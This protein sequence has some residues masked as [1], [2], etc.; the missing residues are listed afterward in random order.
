[1]QSNAFSNRVVWIIM[2]IVVNL[3]SSA[4]E[5][6]EGLAMD[7]VDKRFLEAVRNDDDAAYQHARDEALRLP[8][9]DFAALLQSL[10]KA[11]TWQSM[12]IHDALRLRREQPDLAADFDDRLQETIN[13]PTLARDGTPVYSLYKRSTVR[14][15]LLTPEHD[16][17]RFEASLTPKTQLHDGA[18]DYLR[19]SLI[20]LS[21]RDEHSL[22]RYI[23]LIA[24]MPEWA[25]TGGY[26]PS[27]HVEI[28]AARSPTLIDPE[29]SRLVDVYKSL[30]RDGAPL[31]VAI[32]L[33]RAIAHGSPK[34]STP[35]LTAIRRHELELMPKQGVEPWAVRNVDELRNK[36]RE[37]TKVIRSLQR[38]QQA[39]LGRADDEEAIEAL[40]RNLSAAEEQLQRDRTVL[41]A[42]RLW[43][44]LEDAIA[45][46][47]AAPDGNGNGRN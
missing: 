28:I 42:V 47:E 15:L 5:P 24:D 45:K 37:T 19:S 34:V 9:D 10:D 21:Q 2:S 3:V 17:L 26:H 36:T 6:G 46:T 22:R 43:R 20:H 11:G 18:R 8:P 12:A 30:R 23:A 27:N 7:S 41:A 13:N 31:G 35:A 14:G 33:V 16:T 25:S 38:K 1:M 44:T 32:M 39:L 4:A 40:Q 29:I